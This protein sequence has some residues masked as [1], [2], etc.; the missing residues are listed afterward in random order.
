MGFDEVM[1]ALPS[2]A[3]DIPALV[4]L[5]V[6]D[7]TDR[8]RLERKARELGVAD[9]VRFTGRIAE[10]EKADHYRLADAY[11]MPSR[12]EGFGFVLLEAMACGVPTV[13]SRLD[14][15]REAVRDGMLGILVD[16]SD[17]EDVKRGIRE[18]LARGR[19]EPPAGL[20]F[21]SFDNFASRTRR[22]VDETARPNRL[23]GQAA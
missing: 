4:Y 9:R 1:D 5:L 13:A 14:G 8:E 18:A 19:G 3:R 6:G 12:G 20:D 10:S 17:P 2:L 22:L 23:R 11:V 7:G 21:F 15:G 16:P